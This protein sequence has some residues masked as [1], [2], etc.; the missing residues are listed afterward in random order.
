MNAT[1]FGKATAIAAAA[2]MM[3]SMAA[4]SGGSMDDSG[5]SAGAASGNTI[6]LGSI[7]TNSGTAAAYGEAELKGFKLAISEINAK[8]GLNGKKIKLESMDDKGDATEASN[9]FNKLAGDNSVL[10][11]LGPTISSTTAAVAP[12][13]DQSKLPAIAPAA[14]SDSIATG[15]YLFRTCFKDS[16]QG[17]I[18]AKFAAETLKVK[19]VAV[20][21]GTG[22]PYSSGV[23]KA[24]AAAAKKAGL[25]VVDEENSSSA[26]DT[27][28]S[29][30]LQKI[31]ASGAEFLY[32][33]YYYSVAGP[34]I[35]PQARSLGYK[36]YVMGPDGYD[37]LKL[38]GD[39]SQYDKVLYTTHYSPDDTSNSKVQDFIKSYKKANNNQ[40]PNTFTA[41]AY[42]S[43][44]MFKQAYEKAGKNATREQVR[45]AISGMS[46]SG[47]TGKFT[48]DKKGS[49]NKS[50][51][52]LE[53]KDGKPTYRTTIQPS[54][55]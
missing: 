5:S 46:F 42:D 52:V 30:Q 17:E 22:D 43:V 37:G 2:T 35:I 21:Y 27:E 33:P 7:T 10:A 3:M 38:T 12:L 18:A 13:A 26:D 1:F 47:V 4:C 49:P 6:T 36:G 15:G 16:Y 54:T 11:V 53:L 19:K 45:N 8:G 29:S 34:Y 28:Y 23:G 41:L 39:K 31:Q 20:L 25:D 9:A 14:T 24:F 48:L 55:K 32:A 51:I 44:Y 40:E 50:V